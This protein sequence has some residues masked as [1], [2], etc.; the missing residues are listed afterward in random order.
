MRA[1]GQ[2]WAGLMMAIAGLVACAA[3]APAHAQAAAATW[4]YQLK[5]PIDTSVGASTFDVD[6]FDTPASTVAE[7]KAAGRTVICYVNVGAVE[8]WRPDSTLPAEVR[9]N[10]LDGWPGEFWLDIRRLDL[11]EPY[12][13]ARFDQ[14]RAKG[15]DGVEPDNV[16]GYANDSGFDLTADDQLAYN[17]MISRLA[18]ER[19]LTVGLKND[20]DQVNELVNDF[21]F[22][23][24]EQ[25]HEYDECGA[26]RPF[27]A[28][29]KPVFNAEYAARYR[30]A[31]AALCAASRREGLTTLVLPLA[32]DG[33]F[34]LAC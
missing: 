3:P 24:N 20:L 9:G 31:P 32:L 2:V 12:I 22:A 34:R 25:C 33:S 14:C 17:R 30:R 11:L 15:F 29:G 27:V 23:V 28:A 6:L 7:L 26:L 21:D 19:G 13:A 16:D 18:R 10:E 1:A 5:G 8:D 4:Q